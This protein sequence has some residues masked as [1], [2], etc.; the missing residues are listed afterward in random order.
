MGRDRRW[1]RGSM[2]F[3]EHDQGVGN[4]TAA[5]GI[6]P[7]ES[8]RHVPCS[9]R[10]TT[11]TRFPLW[12]SNGMRQNANAV[13][14]KPNAKGETAV[15]WCRRVSEPWRVGVLFSQSGVMAV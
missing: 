1:G 6:N 9:R 13:I 5:A 11:L 10:R 3:D 8:L 2:R 7:A 12:P 14:T 15:T 4:L